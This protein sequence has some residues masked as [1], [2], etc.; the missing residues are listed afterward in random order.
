MI[1]WCSKTLVQNPWNYCLVLTQKELEK[2]LKKNKI[3]EIADDDERLKSAAATVS[4]YTSPKG[5]KIAIVKLGQNY[6]KYS[7]IVMYSLLVHEATHIWQAVRETLYEDEPSSEFE[8]Y[9]IQKISY[10]LMLAYEKAIKKGK[11]K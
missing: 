8:A 7:K 3:N 11:K 2:V 9:S 4:F 5:C 10:E 6:K 1:A